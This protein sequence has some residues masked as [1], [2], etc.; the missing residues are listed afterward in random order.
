MGAKELMTA[1]RAL[2]RGVLVEPAAVLGL[3]TAHADLDVAVAVDVLTSE[4]N[5]KGVRVT[6][7]SWM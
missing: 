3:G 1:A 2:R 6:H 4:A 5:V 7:L